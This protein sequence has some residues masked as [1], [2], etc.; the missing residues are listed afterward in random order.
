MRVE[1]QQRL[2]VR[3]G[4]HVVDEE[5]HPDATIGGAQDGSDQQLAD[6]VVVPDVVLQVEAALGEID[7]GETG[8]ERIG[9]AGNQVDAGRCVQLDH[10]LRHDVPERGGVGGIGERRRGG[11]GSR[12]RQ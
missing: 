8:Q 11:D 4:A 7:E 3:R 1:Q 5:A 9:T 2:I 12:L 10:S 6:R